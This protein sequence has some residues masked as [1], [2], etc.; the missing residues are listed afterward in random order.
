MFEWNAALYD[1]FGKER[2]QPCLDLIN[3]LPKRN[4]KNIIDIGCGTGISTVALSNQFQQ[5]HIVGVD[6]SEQMLEAAK[7]LEINVDWVK[8]DCSMPLEDLGQFDLVFS[9]AFLQ[10]LPNQE[11]F[12]K[13]TK[14]LF[15]ED[16]VLAIQVPNWDH[17]PIKV[18]IDQVVEQFE[19]LK[20]PIPLNAHNHSIHTY[21]DMLSEHYDVVEIWQTNYN[22]VMESY[23]AI[24]EFVR[25]A[26]LRPYLDQLD[27]GRQSLFIEEIKKRLPEIYSTQVD[28]KILFIFERI[29]FIAK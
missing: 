23:E 28:G 3:R 17:M 27:V 25:G 8:R 9:N 12:L 26:G 4:Y 16:G 21:Y 19:E 5:A 2:V 11:G 15:A 13:Q 14:A 29:L 24:I 10:W 1:Q 6:L 20:K 22:H 7:T 18:C